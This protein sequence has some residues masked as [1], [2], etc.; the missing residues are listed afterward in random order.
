MG[1]N[2]EQMPWVGSILN[3]CSRRQFLSSAAF[4][5]ASLALAPM[6]AGA[7]RP[8]PGTRAE[9]CIFVSLE[10]GPSQIDLFD[11]KPKLRELHGQ[12]LPESLAAKAQQSGIRAESAVLMGSPSRF[13]RQGASG[14]EWC[15]LLPHLASCADD[16]AVVRSMHTEAISHHPGQL[17]MHTGAASTGR[18]ALGAWL[19]YAAGRGTG[20]LPGYVVLPAERGVSGGAANRSRGFLPEHCGGVPFGKLVEAE[21]E[22]AD[23]AGESAETLA[24]YGVDRAPAEAA[25]FSRDCLRARRLVERGVRFVALHHGSWDHHGDIERGLALNC[26]AVDR[27]LAALLRDLERRGL[28]DSTLVVCAGEFGR[29]PVSE[30]VRGG[31]APGRGHHPS[32]FSLW[33]AGGGV[34]GGRVIGAT[35]EL[36]WEIVEDPVSVHDLHATVLH[37]F[38]VDCAELGI[39]DGAGTV[40][41]G[42]IA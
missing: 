12:P 40:V 19:A 26:A 17:L 10:G 23:L 37:L 9:R 14:V 6:L 21:M 5:A 3:R 30:A 25:A 15:E 13:S 20:E 41:R 35:D 18:P 22:R 42:L 36:G 24:A 32:A 1:P 27:P 38:G 11:P 28:L 8:S 33:M 7:G 34:R 31:G 4:G 39:G 16:I 2:R 29:T